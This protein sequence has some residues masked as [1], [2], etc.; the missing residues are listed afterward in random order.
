LKVHLCTILDVEPSHICHMIPKDH[1]IS[2][3]ICAKSSEDNVTH[4]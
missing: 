2:L 3:Y 4:K 1:M